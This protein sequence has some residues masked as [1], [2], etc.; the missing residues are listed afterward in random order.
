[1]IACIAKGFFSHCRAERECSGGISLQGGQCLAVL[2][3][4]MLE[5]CVSKNIVSIYTDWSFSNIWGVLEPNEKASDLCVFWFIFFYK[6]SVFPE[7]KLQRDLCLCPKS[8]WMQLDRGTVF[9]RTWCRVVLITSLSLMLRREGPPISRVMCWHLCLSESMRV[10][11]TVASA[12]K[13]AKASCLSSFLL[14]PCL[15]LRL[16]LCLRTVL[17]NRCDHLDQFR[18]QTDFSYN[19]CVAHVFS[20]LFLPFFQMFLL[21]TEWWKLPFFE[22][23]FRAGYLS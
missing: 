5:F 13:G 21:R 9:L 17:Q 2:N 22:L 14:N 23:V 10:H 3:L 11:A 20:I 12:K 19:I 8:R 18:Q 16:C 4:H 15:C 1:M 7:K 6:I